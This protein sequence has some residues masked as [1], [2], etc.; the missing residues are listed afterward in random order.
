MRSRRVMGFGMLA[1]LL[2]GVGAG[3]ALAGTKS[4][5][6]VSSAGTSAS[7]SDA[8]G[9]RGRF[10]D[11]AARRLGVSR[12][13]LDAALEATA[14]ADVAFAEENA[15]FGFGINSREQLFVRDLGH[16]DEHVPPVDARAA[17]ALDPLLEPGVADRRGAHV[18]AAAAGPQVQRGS[19]HGHLPLWLH[20]HGGQG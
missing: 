12:S 1:L 15:S 17:E 8:A 14:L 7:A 6:G 2:T 10:L 18:D 19:D 5:A 13:K 9:W 4:T 16:R 3:A 11:D 20:G